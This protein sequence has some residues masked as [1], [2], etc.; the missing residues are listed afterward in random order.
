LRVAAKR[1]PSNTVIRP[2]RPEDRAAVEDIVRDAYAKWVALIGVQPKPLRA[3]Y[4]ALIDAGRVFVLTSEGSVAGL[5]VL[6]AEPDALLVENVAVRPADQGRGLGRRLLA[7][8]E[9]QARTLGKPAIR[10]YT[11]ELMTTNLALYEALGYR[12]TGRENVTRGQT[13]HLRKDLVAEP[14]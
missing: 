10:L 3:D 13:V 7:F 2:A 9:A 6:T 12:E 14:D 1:V 8:A 5:I 4:R 11:H